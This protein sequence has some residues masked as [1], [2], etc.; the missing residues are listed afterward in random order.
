VYVFSIGC[1]D[2]VRNVLIILFYPLIEVGDTF[3][4]RTI[5]YELMQFD[6]FDSIVIFCSAPPFYFTADIQGRERNFK[7]E[8]PQ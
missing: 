7:K 2:I 3:S 8:L 4:R 6:I 5:H 1:R